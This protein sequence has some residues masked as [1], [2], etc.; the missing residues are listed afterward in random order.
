MLITFD[1]IID[2]WKNHSVPIYTKNT[3]ELK[4]LLIGFVLWFHK[5]NDN[6]LS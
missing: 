1:K 2:F 3:F 5:I 6:I 4:L